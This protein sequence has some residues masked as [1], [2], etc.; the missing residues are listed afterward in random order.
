MARNLKKIDPKF[1]TKTQ[2]YDKLEI[3]APKGQRRMGMDK[4]GKIHI[5]DDK[6]NIIGSQG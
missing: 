1:N 2:K 5:Y 4:N 6:G 3:K